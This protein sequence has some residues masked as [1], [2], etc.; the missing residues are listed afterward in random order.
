MEILKIILI[1]FSSITTIVGTIVVRF[2]IPIGVVLI[3][4]ELINLVSYGIWTII[5]YT[6]GIWFLGFILAL[7][8]V[9]VTIVAAG[10]INGKYFKYNSRRY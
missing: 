2:T 9:A 5:G 7:L 8:G 4:L 3:I 6:L 1:V 10:A